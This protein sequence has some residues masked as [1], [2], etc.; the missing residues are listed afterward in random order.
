MATQ[1]VLFVP[2]QAGSMSLYASK[3]VC[4]FVTGYEE[5]TRDGIRN[6]AF[7][8]LQHLARSGFRVDT[9]NVRHEGD[10]VYRIALPR[11]GRIVGFFSDGSFV[12][13]EAFR[14]PG[15]RLNPDNRAL[16]KRVATARTA[17]D[18]KIV[19]RL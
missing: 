13:L 7:T 8:K 9:V 1:V 3:K 5:R 16:I 19:E 17:A 10:S 12:A 14:K 11:L 18:W 2:P 4:R 15:Q 6:E